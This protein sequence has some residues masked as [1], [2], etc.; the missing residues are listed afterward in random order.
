[1]KYSDLINV[2]TFG[3]QR[4]T[5]SGDRGDMVS[6]CRE[7]E[8]YHPYSEDLLACPSCESSELTHGTK[9][10]LEGFYRRKRKA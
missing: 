6:Y 5:F 2:A 4:E 8:T 1:M 9:A 3:K 7:C 10:S